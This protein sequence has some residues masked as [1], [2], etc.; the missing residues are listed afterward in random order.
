MFRRGVRLTLQSEAAEC[1]LACLAMISSYHGNPMSLQTLRQMH[2][3]SLRGVTLAQLMKV[4]SEINLTSRAVRLEVHALDRLSM[5]AVLHWN[6]D[7]FVVLE[8]ATRSTVT[9]LDPAIGRQTLQWGKVSQHFTGV[10][11][12][13]APSEGFKKRKA[14]AGLRL[15]D[16]FVHVSSLYGKLGQL[17]LL[18]IA[19]QF[20]ALLTPFYAQIVVD[21]VITT[22]D[23]E[24]LTLL[25]VAFIAFGL[26]NLAIGV[27]R[28]VLVMRFGA[29]LQFEWAARLFHHLIRLPLTFFERRHVGDVVSRFRALQPIQQLVTTT[30]V[31]AAIDGI[32]AST[33]LVV[34]FLYS[35]LL[36]SLA[37]I[38][39]VAYVVVR[40]LSYTPHKAAAHEAL[41]KS[42]QESSHFLET[43]RGIQAIKSFGKEHVREA[44]WQ[45]RSAETVKTGMRTLL[46]TLVESTSLQVIF[47]I[48][49]CVVIWIGAHLVIE[50]HLTIGML[51][52]FLSYKTQFT[53][54]AAALVDKY[55]EVKLV[56]VNLER[57]S[58]IA[59]TDREQSG[60]E[61]LRL[62]SAALQGRISG[63]ALRYGYSSADPLIFH[64]FD[65]DVHQGEC[66][67]ITGSSGRGKTTLIKILM[68]LIEPDGG[69][70]MVDDIDIRSLPTSYFRQSVASVMQEDS[71]LSGSLHEN[72][73]FFEPVIDRDRV[74]LCAKLAC[75]DDE[76][77]AMPM[78]YSTHIG[79]M[80]A[81][82]SG[83]QKQRVLL[84]R[85][86]YCNPAILFLDEATSHL[87]PAT[88]M[89][90]HQNLKGLKMTRVIVAHRR[91]TLEIADR[92]INLDEP[93]DSLT[94]S[95]S[96][97]A[98]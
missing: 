27:F 25:A 94:H 33:T 62:P 20:F 35:P 77:R 75:I 16:F 15:R 67:A 31:E 74:Q 56:S 39:V 88:E 22:H 82:L 90:L 8:S 34:L 13:L 1:G 46:I 26:I 81:A 11:L 86:L 43:L 64:D 6:L 66:V 80:G 14:S 96:L 95:S 28:S 76:I 40:L 23:T 7:H 30:I 71:L 78:G 84:A 52:A 38:S 68:G 2:G 10:A 44:V 45:N 87:D 60:S 9:I 98:A 3:V 18:S 55:L 36:T 21:Q 79:D 92:V 63:K 57:L 49:G 12:E 85:A 48:E 29:R 61:A 58:D 93:S 65:I 70:V 5:P 73:G 37:I 19:L 24:L 72:I 42:A 50:N 4:A 91:E 53:T 17:F 69:T 51:M 89:R 41:I 47:A 97:E 54:R 59:L 32:M 83:G